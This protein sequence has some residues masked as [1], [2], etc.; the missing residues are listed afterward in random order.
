MDQ[1]ASCYHG[2]GFNVGG[3][4]AEDG[5]EAVKKGLQ[6]LVTGCNNLV[7]HND[8]KICVSASENWNIHW[9]CG[10][11]G[12]VQTDPK[13][14]LST[15]EEEYKNSNMHQT[16]SALV[17]PGIIQVV[18]DWCQD[19]QDVTGLENKEEELFV[20]F[21]KFPEENEK[22]LMELDFSLRMGQIGLD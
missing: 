6:S 13:V 22:L 5:Q 14:S 20:V 11:V 3:N 1:L 15:E 19:V 4:I 12:L 7:E 10:C 16:H 8:Q 9:D 18:Q 17:G 21:T 2:H